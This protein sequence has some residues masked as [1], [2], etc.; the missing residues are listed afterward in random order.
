[1]TINAENDNTANDG[2]TVS[3]GNID[4]ACLQE[5]CVRN[6]SVPFTEVAAELNRII[7]CGTHYCPNQSEVQ[8][9]PPQDLPTKYLPVWYQ[10]SSPAPFDIALQDQII[11]DAKA[12]AATQAPSCLDGHKKSAVSY[13]FTS[14]STSTNGIYMRVCYVCCGQ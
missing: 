4:N 1:L 3:W 5:V 12:L 8:Y 13:Q 11:S 9:Q 14:D 2:K 7:S 6:N 10:Q